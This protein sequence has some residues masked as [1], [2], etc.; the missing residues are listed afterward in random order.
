MKSTSFITLPLVFR[1]AC[2]WSTA[3]V[4]SYEKQ[5]AI[6]HLYLI[7]DTIIDL[8]WSRFPMKQ[9]TFSSISDHFTAVWKYLNIEMCDQI[10]NRPL[11][12][13]PSLAKANL[14]TRGVPPQIPPRRIDY[15]NS[16][17]LSQQNA[18]VG[19]SVSSKSVQNIPLHFQESTSEMND[20]TSSIANSSNAILPDTL[21]NIYEGTPVRYSMC[22]SEI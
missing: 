15:E 17:R 21:H 18:V 7:S 19:S 10:K 5:I 20:I 13:I 3:K 9:N 12:P 6:L 16:K 11:P 2:F 22:S 14:R 4:M 8:K 1:H